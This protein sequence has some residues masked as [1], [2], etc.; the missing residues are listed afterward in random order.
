MANIKSIKFIHLLGA[1]DVK[2]FQRL[3]KLLNNSNNAF[4]VSQHLFVT[5]FERVYNELKGYGKI[6][7][8]ASKK[9]VLTADIVNYCAERCEWLFVHN[10]CK[11]LEV[12]K[13]KR[14]H[15]KRIL[16]RTWGDDAG[17]LY[18]NCSIIKVIIKF[19][20]NCISRNAYRDFYAVGV[21]NSVDIVDITKKFGKM[22]TYRMP[23]A[24]ENTYDILTQIINENNENNNRHI[25][26]LVGHS[27]Y[28]NDN[29]FR[30]ID[31]LIAYKNENVKFYFPLSYGDEKYIAKVKNYAK[32]HLCEKAV[33]VENFMPYE[34]FARFLNGMDVAILAGKNSYALGNVALL[35]FFGKKLYINE[36]GI[37][38]KAFMHA[39]VPFGNV[40]DLGKITFE[41][42]SRPIVYNE[43][44]IREFAPKPYDISVNRWKKII[45]DLEAKD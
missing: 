27:G 33:F 35:L 30:I 4:D 18:D 2:F 28:K 17:Y 1:N 38:A 37:I 43:A 10:M 12:L 24:N 23:Y 26:I 40:S 42:I 19:I 16:W 21:A 7:L 6:E 14:E 39:N 15:R 8:L 31:K 3:I 41:D 32:K 44:V 11:P 25:K 45:S 29:H 34:E 9:E 20:I 22:K 5:P 13:I 36:K